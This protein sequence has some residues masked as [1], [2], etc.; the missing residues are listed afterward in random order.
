M[1]YQRQ[2]LELTDHAQ[3]RSVRG[4]LVSIKFFFATANS[5]A[6][7]A[8]S[9]GKKM[10]PGSEPLPGDCTCSCTSKP[11]MKVRSTCLFGLHSFCRFCWALYDMAMDRIC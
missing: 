6:C 2:F 3:P 1:Q 4:F 5:A 7:F 8:C 10:K 9:F 11:L